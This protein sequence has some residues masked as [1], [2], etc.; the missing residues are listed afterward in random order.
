VTSPPPTAPSVEQLPEPT[1]DPLRIDPG[2]DPILGLARSSTSPAEFVGLVQQAVDRNPG[3]DEA[4]AGIEEA[5]AARR[6]ARAGLFPSGEFGLNST[7]SI[8]R[9]FDADDNDNIVER[10]RGRA[11][12]DLTMT[13]NQM[14][15]DWGATSS[16]IAAAGARLRAAASQAE[17]SADEVA[18]RAIAAWYDVFAYRALATLGSAFTSGQQDLRAAIQTR[19]SQ[20]VS[21]PG[22]L[23]RVENYIATAE[24]DLA[25]YRR[26]LANAEARFQEIYGV[27]PP[28][29]LGRAPILRG[30]SI[31]SRD[32][33]QA[34]ARSAPQVESAE[35]LARAARQEARAEYRATLPNFSAG[36]DAGRY[37]LLDSEDYDVRGRVTA[38]YRF[39]GGVEARVEQFEARAE[40]AEARAARV[41]N[42][43][44]REASIAWSDVQALQQQLAALESSYVASR[45]SRDVLAERFRIARGTLFDLLESES[46][47]FNVAALYVRAITELDAA[48]YVLLSR[49]GQLLPTLSI[50][51]PAVE[52]Q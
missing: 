17:V 6:E 11:R 9:N 39:L 12:T 23:P 22:D 26:Q 15:F 36:I 43:A 24:A 2:A 8:A 19:I 21:A 20:G 45:Q 32:A 28:A 50:E 34:L 52:G 51:P 13:L 49:T 48:R 47:Y 16:R 4:Q 33:A 27:P 5:Q 42:E 40:Q 10:S 14:L 1:L 29:D 18:L 41:R 38:R 35:A 7:R 31:S 3:V 44:E 25:R 30:P 37:D 46:G